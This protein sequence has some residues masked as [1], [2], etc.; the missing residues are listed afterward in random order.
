M[1]LKVIGVIDVIGEEDIDHI[2]EDGE[3]IIICH[4]FGGH[5]VPIHI[6]IH[7]DITFGNKFILLN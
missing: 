1:M 2:E 5:I 3:E 4:I 6:P 7:M